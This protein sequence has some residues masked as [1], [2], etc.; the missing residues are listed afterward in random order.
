MDIKPI[1]T[2]YKGYRFR[3][4]LEARYAVFFDVLGI[5]W[6]YEKEGF[7][8]GEAG[9]YLPDFW[10]PDNDT[11]AEVKGKEFTDIENKKVADLCN[12]TK[13]PVIK[14]VGIPEFMESIKGYLLYGDYTE[15]F[16]TDFIYLLI[17]YGGREK[18]H[19][20]FYPKKMYDCVFK[21]GLKVEYIAEIALKVKKACEAAKSARFEHGENIRNKIEVNNKP[22]SGYEIFRFKY[23][24]RSNGYLMEEILSTLE[25]GSPSYIRD[26]IVALSYIPMIPIGPKNYNKIDA[27]SILLKYLPQEELRFLLHTIGEEDIEYDKLLNERSKSKN[28]RYPFGYYFLESEYRKHSDFEVRETYTCI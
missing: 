21:N 23:C 24:M 16:E 27:A 6:E 22:L 2:S 18:L 25:N 12:I 4:R 5:K 7:D 20:G 9:Y 17:N 26:K 11:W 1:E 28:K 13:R 8:L 3:S 19:A 14:L 10:F 15:A